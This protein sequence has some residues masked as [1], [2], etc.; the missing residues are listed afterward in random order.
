MPEFSVQR[1]DTPIA[2]PPRERAAIPL[3]RKLYYS[4]FCVLLLLLLCE[5]AVRVRANMRYGKANSGNIIDSLLV[6]DEKTGLQI[7]RAGLEQHA[8]LVSIGINSLGFRGQ[9]FELNKA[10]D[11]IRIACIG[12]STTFCAEAS[13]NDLSLIHI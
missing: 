1:T 13:D 4:A 11:T 12:A 9:P 7:P 2:K 3:T 5:V 10:E 8:K 6:K